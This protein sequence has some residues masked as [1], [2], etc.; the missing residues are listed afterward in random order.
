ML[1][2]GNPASIMKIFSLLPCVCLLLVSNIAHAQR[3]ALVIGNATYQNEK[4]LVNPTND[5]ELIADVLRK[6]L[7]FDEALLHKSNSEC[8]APFP[9]R[10]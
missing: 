5:A 1:F 3:V 2:F 4:P 7:Q 6:D 8:N 9:G 10:I